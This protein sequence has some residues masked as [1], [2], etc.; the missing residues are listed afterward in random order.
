MTRMMTRMMDDDTDGS[1]RPPMPKDRVW[2]K[3][4]DDSDD[5]L[6]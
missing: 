6:G 5:G 1:Q 3:D 2:D 4:R